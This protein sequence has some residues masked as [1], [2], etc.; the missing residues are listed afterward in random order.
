MYKL[1][2]I[3]I[4]LLLLLK[5]EIAIGDNHDK[6]IA[7]SIV[8]EKASWDMMT[9]VSVSCISF[10][11]QLPYKRSVVKNK[12]QIRKLTRLFHCLKPVDLK[13]G[14]D[15]RCKVYFY[16]LGQLL[17]TA[18]L[19]KGYCLM[20]GDYYQTSIKTINLIDKLTAKAERATINPINTEESMLERAYP[21]GKDS[22]HKF[23][24]ERIREEFSR[25]GIWDTLDLYIM[26]RADNEGNTIDVKVGNLHGDSNKTP[27]QVVGFMTALFKNEIKWIP[28]KERMY[29]DIIFIKIRYI[30]TFLQI[31][32]L[33]TNNLGIHATYTPTYPFY[34]KD[35][36]GSNRV[37][38]S[39][40]GE[41]EQVNH[42]YP[43]GSTFYGETSTD[44]RFK[45]CGKELDKMQA[46]LRLS[47]IPLFTRDIKDEKR[48][49]GKRENV[50]KT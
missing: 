42:Y 26:C 18:C 16:R 34:M 8:I 28:D 44:H 31:V 40:T 4:I 3:C 46:R 7:D 24:Q 48:N 15:V 41:A 27:D 39:V 29:H 9:D 47:L 17:Y 20:N 45:Y 12:R 25:I 21:N 37:V 36:L 6:D 5:F 32:Q 19:N 22:L 10:E 30:P 2:K 14:L 11:R 13:Y 33:G 35:H 38:A 23:L 43:Y 49:E 1:F 50:L